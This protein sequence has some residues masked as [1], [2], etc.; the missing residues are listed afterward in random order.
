MLRYGEICH[1]VIICR[2]ADAPTDSPTPD[3]AN[4]IFAAAEPISGHMNIGLVVLNAEKKVVQ[5]SDTGASLLGVTSEQVLGQTIEHLLQQRAGDSDLP[6]DLNSLV[7]RIASRDPEP[8]DCEVVFRRRNYHRLKIT[9]FQLP[10]D[11]GNDGT[12]LLIRDLTL[13]PGNDDFI[14]NLSHELLNPITSVM[15]YSELLK[16]A[17]LDQIQGGWLNTIHASGQ[18]LAELVDD[19]LE[20]T[21]L[22]QVGPRGPEEIFTLAQVI[23]EVLADAKPRTTSHQIEVR[24]EPHLPMVKTGRNALAKI[25]RNLLRNAIN[26][27]PSGSTVTFSARH[28]EQ[29]DRVVVS[30]EDQGQG[31]AQSDANSVFTPFYRSRQL[32]ETSDSTPSLCLY[33]AKSLVENFGEE[34]WCESDTHKGATFHFSVAAA[35]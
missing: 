17:P 13:D 2:Q 21:G 30:V 19:L 23:D 11:Q 4:V 27:G 29:A 34:I 20:V 35:P 14:S 1:G 8:Q 18:R 12:G 16:K 3:F 5:C 22:E 9:I 24:M 25:L 28:E 31:I 33:I 7:H 10:V 32:A 26:Y 6:A 15:G